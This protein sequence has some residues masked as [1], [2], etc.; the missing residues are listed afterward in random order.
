MSNFNQAVEWLTERY[1]VCRIDWNKGVYIVLSGEIEYYGPNGRDSEFDSFL[2]EDIEATDWEIYCEEHEWFTGFVCDKC[3][4]PE[5]S[6]GD[7]GSVCN[8]D[9]WLYHHKCIKDNVCKNCGIKKPETELKTLKDMDYKDWKCFDDYEKWFSE[10]TLK[11]GAIKDINFFR[12][13]RSSNPDY[14]KTELNGVE[15]YIVWKNNL[16]E[17]DLK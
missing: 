13:N 10:S 7:M 11:Q 2:R 8:C 14:S 9:N 4:N 3:G 5:L 1:K 12:K 15:K 6:A 17:E 16:T